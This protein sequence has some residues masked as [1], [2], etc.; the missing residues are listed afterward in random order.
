MPKQIIAVD[1]DDTI[2]DE[3]TAVRLFH[4]KKY[5]TKHTSED[6][7]APGQYGTFWKHIWNTDKAETLRRYE[8]FLIYKFGHNLT[9]IPGAI[10]ALKS[11]KQRYEL[12]IVTSRDKRGVAM[13]HKDLNEHYPN[14]FKD[15][16]FVPLWG[17]GKRVTK[18]QISQAIGAKYLIDD[19]FEHC[20]LA[21]EAGVEALVYGVYGWNQ[22]QELQPHMTRVK[23]WAEVKEFFDVRG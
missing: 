1:A 18:A 21:A 2:F 14:I 10:E 5:G 4:N 11:L 16:H 13:T 23:N 7:L 9:P 12:V 17:A 19:S 3:D 15:V 20:L 6:Y 8:E 22:A